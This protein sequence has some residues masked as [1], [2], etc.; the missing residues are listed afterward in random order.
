MANTTNYN[1]ETPDDTDLVKDGAAAIRT[2]GSSVDTTTK[3]LNPSTT[4]GDI[5]YR[6]ATANTNTRLGI[7]STGQV[8]TV[9]GGVPSWATP[10]GGSSNTAGKNGVLNSG[11]NV[12]QRGTSLAGS[13]TAFSA[14]R[15]QSYRA[16]AGSTYSRQATGD[17]ANL[18]FIQYCLRMQRDSGN[19]AT[20][21]LFLWQN[22]ETVNSIPFAGKTVTFSFYARKGAN[23]S[24][25]S[26]ALAY[27]VY[28]GTGTDQNQL[29]GYTG[30]ATPISATATLTSTWQRFSSSATLD[31]TATEINTQF[32]YNPTGTAGA[33]DYVEITG[34]QLE[35]A[36]TA[37][38]YSPATPT[39]ATELAACQRY[40]YKHIASENVAVAFASGTAIAQTALNFPVTMRIAPTITLP[41]SGSSTGQIAFLNSSA[42]YPAT[43]GTL[44]ANRI[45]VSTFSITTTSATSAFT[46]GN[47]SVLFVTGTTQTAYEASA[48]L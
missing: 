15:W 46:A 14:D 5:E 26:D 27:Q 32:Y 29:A 48:E 1:W 9:A 40:Y 36:S 37:S 38:A 43:I 12:W 30:Q 24:A 44:A 6:S 45:S 8:L 11:F 22:F 41:A 3:A 7:G 18:P 33:A 34:V 13:T 19:T 21:G 25:T 39:Y 20:N 10:S 2:L 35:I 4:L 47:A 16:V 23:Y 28:T 31:S 42:N 17:T